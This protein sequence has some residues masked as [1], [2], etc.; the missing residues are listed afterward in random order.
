MRDQDKFNRAEKLHD[1]K[2]RFEDEALENF[3]L[4]VA[5]WESDPMS[6]QC[7]D[8]RIVERA[9]YLRA[10]LADN[11]KKTEELGLGWPL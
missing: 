5:E 10:L 6:V 2:V 11:A 1:D 8:L 3:K 4:V 9:K 7:F